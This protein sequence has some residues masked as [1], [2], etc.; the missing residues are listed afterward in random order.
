MWMGGNACVVKELLK[1]SHTD[2][3][4]NCPLAAGCRYDGIAKLL[5]MHANIDMNAVTPD[6]RTALHAACHDVRIKT[7]RLLFEHEDLDVNKTD[8]NGSTPLITACSAYSNVVTELYDIINL[9]LMHA[10]T[11]VNAATRDG[12]ST[13]LH[14]ACQSGDEKIVHLLLK[15]QGIDVDKADNDGNTALMTACRQGC[16][17][18]V[19]LLINLKKADINKTNKLDMTSFEIACSLHHSDIACRLFDVSHIREKI[20]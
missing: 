18:S 19:R 4:L 6:K 12:R 16:A 17:N 5:L 3:N 13:A 1:Y 14:M 8:S 2:V 7:V 11:D 20:R 10:D 9:L 15:H